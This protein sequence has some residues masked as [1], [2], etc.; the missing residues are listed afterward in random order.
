MRGRS[1]LLQRL[2]SPLAAP[3]QALPS[4]LAWH[5]GALL[6]V[7]LAPAQLWRGQ[8][9]W[10]LAP[11]ELVPVLLVGGAYLALALLLALAA[12]RPVG[13][14]P[15]MLPVAGLACY[16]ALLALLWVRRDL[17]FSWGMMAVGATLGVGL[18]LVPWLAGRAA[19]WALSSLLVALGA[20]GVA[21][22]S[23]ADARGHDR[24]RTRHIGTALH[25]LAVERHRDLV[26]LPLESDGGGL[27]AAG[28][29]F[30]LVTGAGR[31]YRLAWSANRR[32]RAE[33]LD[34][35]APLERAAFLADKPRGGNASRLRVTDLLVDASGGTLRV[36]VAH[37]FWH[38][39]ERC[40]TLRVSATELPRTG[41]AAPWRTVYESRPC[42]APTVAFDD[43]D[44]GGRLAFGPG[45][46][47][48]LTIGDH[49]FHG[50]APDAALAQD[51]GDY[52][53]IL[54]LDGVG[55]ARIFSRGHRNPQGLTVDRAGRIWSTEHGPQGGDEIN[56][57]SDGGNYGWPLA[58]YGTD[59]GLE[60]WPL[61][62]AG[63][64]PFVA[65]VHA[66]VPSIGIS[67]LIQ[68][69]ARQFPRW[70][71]DLLVASLRAGELLRVRLDG[72]RVAYVEPIPIGRR[73][74]DLAQGS[75]GRILL[76]ID[77]GELVSLAAARR[78]PSGEAVYR[79]CAGCHEQSPDGVA[80]SA[81]ALHGIVGRQVAAAPGFAY[82]DG[83]RQAGGNW[84]RER[85]DAFLADPPAF[86][87][88]TPMA[89]GAVPDGAERRALLDY[90]AARE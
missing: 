84:S 36:F 28:D 34:L 65:P 70:D 37:Q 39:G 19:P 15:V 20:L 7:L 81:P 76:W 89:R 52:G 75:D 59:Y 1:P 11:A 83:L 41:S 73:I 25:L 12:R 62:D 24:E 61:A 63:R 71:G 2:R 10:T 4:A 51:E 69:A 33:R 29:A 50:T 16:G 5:A 46:Q 13:L 35:V 56:L 80:P 77:D 30:L 48:L 79:R 45:G 18:A 86:A 57:V 27:A 9:A 87:P 88:G 68:V 66:F 40:F 54:L 49:G 53:K 55:G 17:P 85:L 3:R 22:W 47:L 82:S 72:T 21:G 26:E 90:L 42:L 44:T 8:P 23:A 31:F 78:A 32:L 43:S 14:R 58:T 6:V 67:D 60:Y 64:G 38:R 74:R